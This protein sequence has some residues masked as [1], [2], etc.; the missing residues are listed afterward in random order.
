MAGLKGSFY[1]LEL[2]MGVKT[3][4]NSLWFLPRISAIGG[5]TRN[6]QNSSFCS[7]ISFFFFHVFYFLLSLAE[8][9]LYSVSFIIF[10]YFLKFYQVLILQAHHLSLLRL[11]RSDLPD[12]GL[13]TSTIPQQVSRNRDDSL[14]VLMNF[15]VYFL[16]G[17]PS[18]RLSS[19]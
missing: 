1:F 13:R 19:M 2:L 8:K 4:S 6:N 5:V 11:N 16:D 9:F 7:L 15:F 14:D 3:W 10:P 17:G 12:L 18:S